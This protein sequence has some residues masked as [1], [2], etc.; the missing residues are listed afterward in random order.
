MWRDKR[1]TVA[2]EFALIGSALAFL[3]MAATDLALAIYAN[4]EIGNAAR[5]GAEYAARNPASYTNAG[6]SA[7]AKAATNATLLIGVTTTPT[8]YCGCATASGVTT[9]TC[10]STCSGGGTTGTYVS[11]KE[12]ASYSPIF[13]AMWGTIL[14]NNSLSMSATSFTRIN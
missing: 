13:A 4:T 3:L 5:A 7:A 9:Q 10:G 6:I 12:S 11:V 1:G 2:I 14:T 8:T